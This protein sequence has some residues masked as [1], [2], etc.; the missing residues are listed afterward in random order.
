MSRPC[1]FIFTLEEAQSKYARDEKSVV[2]NIALRSLPQSHYPKNEAHHIAHSDVEN[3]SQRLTQVAESTA[4]V[5]E[6][7]NNIYPPS[8]TLYT[9]L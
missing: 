2:C 9:A 1:L 4:L 6:T 7:G 5:V 3:A 8:F